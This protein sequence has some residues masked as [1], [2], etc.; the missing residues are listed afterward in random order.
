MGYREAGFIVKWKEK[1]K[2]DIRRDP[3]SCHEYAI[4]VAFGYD[5]T[6]LLIRYF[7]YRY[8]FME[9]WYEVEDEQN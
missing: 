9:M 6:Y 8:Y 1:L 7:D 3:D 2:E 4:A 5:S